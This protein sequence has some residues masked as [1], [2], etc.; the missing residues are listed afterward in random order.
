MLSIVHSAGLSGI[1]GFPVGVECDTQDKIPRFEIIGLPGTAIKESKD[2]VTSAMGNSGF[3]MPEVAITV[4][5]TPADRKKEGS[6]YDLAILISVMLSTGQFHMS[7]MLEK[8]CFIGELSLSGGVLPVRGV[9][10][11]CLAAKEAGL[12]EIFVPAKNAG[13]ASVVD[14]VHIYAVSDVR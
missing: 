13:E 8:S 1:D 7:D 5:L 10:C 11:M 2:R 4:N 9:L 3:L 6:S 12:T 14:G